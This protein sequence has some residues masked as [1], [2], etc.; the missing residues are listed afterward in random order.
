ME[1]V[2]YSLSLNHSAF[3]ISVPHTFTRPE[4]GPSEGMGYGYKLEFISQLN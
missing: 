3:Q 2:R 4:L 1:I